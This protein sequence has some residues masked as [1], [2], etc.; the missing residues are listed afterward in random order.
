MERVA[1]GNSKHIMKTRKAIRKALQN[2]VDGR[3]YSFVEILSPCPT[4]W[5]MDPPDARDWVL[6]EMTRVFPLGVFKDEGET[7]EGDW[8]RK[9]E[10]YDPAAVNKYL[11]SFAAADDC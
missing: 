2:Q 10:P 11:Q 5:K 3:G 1:L 9:V 8:H 4:G 7:R 6:E